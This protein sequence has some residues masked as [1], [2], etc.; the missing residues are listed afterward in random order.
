M[1]VC[2]CV[3]VCACACVCMCM[4][5]VYMRTHIILHMSQRVFIHTCKC[6]NIEVNNMCLND[7]YTVDHCGPFDLYNASGS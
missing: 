6:I 3:C 1:C 4:L 5:V 7:A 2:V